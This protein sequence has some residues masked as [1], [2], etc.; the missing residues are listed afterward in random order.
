MAGDV[1]CLAQAISA[2]ENQP[3]VA[4]AMLGELGDLLGHAHI[5]GITGPLALVR[6]L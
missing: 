3:V 5:V 4:H 6:A 1:R 2:A